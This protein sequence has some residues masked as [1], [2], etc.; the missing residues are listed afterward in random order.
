MTD[1]A[2]EPKLIIKKVKLPGAAAHGGA[3]KVAFADFVTAMMAFF[4]L[5]WLL[6]A[7]TQEQLEWQWRAVWRHICIGSRP[8]PKARSRGAGE[9]LVVKH[10]GR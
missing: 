10:P 1:G 8:R 7:T 3:W 2:P 4:L 6:N 9:Y 5:L